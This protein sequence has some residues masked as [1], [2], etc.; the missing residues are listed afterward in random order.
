MSD[1]GVEK[2]AKIIDGVFLHGKETPNK[3][4]DLPE[5]QYTVADAIDE[6]IRIQQQMR[7][8]GI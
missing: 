7:E 8:E 5:G 6:I 1:T 3:S 4:Y 2:I